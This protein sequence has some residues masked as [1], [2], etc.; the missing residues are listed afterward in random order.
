MPD[1][2]QTAF[3]LHRR[4]YRDTSQI[5]E[6]FTLNYGRISVV[7]KG[8]KRPKSPLKTSL[9]MFQPLLVN[10]QGKHE[11]MTLT[12]AELDK[13]FSAI[14]G[15]YLAWAFYL[16]ELLYRMLH[17]H[18]AYPHVFEHYQQLIHSIINK[19]AVEADLRWFE[20]DVLTRMGYGL[21]LESDENSLPIEANSYYFLEPA[22]S[23]IKTT[24]NEGKHIYLGEHLLA[25][26][27]QRLTTPAHFKAA[28]RLLRHALQHLLGDKP[29]K[30]RELLQ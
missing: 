18:E 2:V 1:S 8:C 13:P 23:P 6:L 27:E 25:L 20:Y 28:K 14:S 9:Q 17:K 21:H 5:I 12:H 15:K 30:S 24:F 7:A 19:V 4:D 29:F 11:L 16:N 22:Q 3:V 26:V 10:W